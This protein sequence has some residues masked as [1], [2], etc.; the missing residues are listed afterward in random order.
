M[1]ENIAMP[2]LL[3]TEPDTYSYDDLE[4]EGETVWDGVTNPQAVGFLRGMKRNEDLVIY[5]S[6][7]DK[8]VIGT[9]KVVSVEDEDPRKPV[10]RIKKGRRLKVQRTLTEMREAP[11]F[12]GSLLLRQ[13]RL[14][15]VPINPEQW[16][17]IVK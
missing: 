12:Q 9:A 10:V 1:I 5:H 7:K 4:R 6:G 15:V 14:S 17:W 3:K 2:F 8:A 16:D 11:E 13:S